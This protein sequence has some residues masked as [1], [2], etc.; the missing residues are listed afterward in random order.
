MGARV[1]MAGLTSAGAGTLG[2]HE[3]W[4]FRWDL[5]DF[6]AAAGIVPDALVGERSSCGTSD[7]MRLRLCASAC[8]SAVAMRRSPAPSRSSSAALDGLESGL[9]EVLADELTQQVKRGMTAPR[10]S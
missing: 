9:D 5:F 10:P 8:S 1:Y 6:Y 7:I 2:Q 3:G 4:R